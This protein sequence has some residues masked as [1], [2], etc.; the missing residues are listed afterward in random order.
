MLD[1]D[2]HAS[3][4]ACQ[5]AFMMQNNLSHEFYQH[6]V[7]YPKLIL[8]AYKVYDCLGNKSKILRWRANNIMPVPPRSFELHTPIV[9]HNP[10]TQWVHPGNVG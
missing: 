5:R 3:M 1:E 7:G 8:L 10:I 4:Q 9:C 6:Y 2:M